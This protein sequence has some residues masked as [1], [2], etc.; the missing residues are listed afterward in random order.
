MLRFNSLPGESA[1]SLS[2]KITA[3]QYRELGDAQGWGDPHQSTGRL[4]TL[5][6]SDCS[7]RVSAPSWIL[8]RLVGDTYN[9]LLLHQPTGLNQYD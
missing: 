4:N 7:E 2:K 9:R 6:P 8:T 5:W 3:H 1:I